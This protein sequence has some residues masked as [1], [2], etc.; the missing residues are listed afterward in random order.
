MRVVRWTSLNPEE[1]GESK[2]GGGGECCPRTGNKKQ[3]N[4]RKGVP[5]LACTVGS[6]KTS[7]P[8]LW[9]LNSSFP[10]LLRQA[11]LVAPLYI[12]YGLGFNRTQ[13][14]PGLQGSTSSNI[15][16]TLRAPAQSQHRSRVRFC[17]F[18]KSSWMAWRQAGKHTKDKTPK[19]P[20][21][22]QW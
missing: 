18:H 20:K 9:I 1:Q 13:M 2:S 21:I 8:Q 7:S 10:G 12:C 5:K 3:P 6:F 4:D 19:I 16:G 17:T 15:W 22:V 11:V 14:H